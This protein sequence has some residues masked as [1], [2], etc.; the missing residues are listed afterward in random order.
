MYLIYNN[1]HKLLP[2]TYFIP[3]VNT[4]VYFTEKIP[5]LKPRLGRFDIRLF[6]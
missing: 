5:V 2:I 3:F 4:L 1:I 6:A